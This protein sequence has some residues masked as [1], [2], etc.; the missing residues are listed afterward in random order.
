L[1]RATELVA[2]VGEHEREGLHPCPDCGAPT[3]APSCAFCRLVARARDQRRRRIPLDQP[4][5]AP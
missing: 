5:S 2:H 3:T 4:V 1:E